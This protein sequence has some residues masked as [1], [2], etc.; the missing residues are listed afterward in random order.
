MMAIAVRQLRHR[1]IL[2]K[3]ILESDEYGGF[4]ECW[5]TIATCWARV[6]PL[7]SQQASGDSA[8]AIRTGGREIQTLSFEVVL[9]ADYKRPKFERFEWK[10]R[11]FALTTQPETQLGGNF[12]VCYAY[13]LLA[14]EINQ[15]DQHDR[16]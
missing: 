12:M 15:G 5:Q 6:M 11:I 3:R 7:L 16:R 4:K 8:R 13:E 14:S 10:N 1:I 2:L 9:S